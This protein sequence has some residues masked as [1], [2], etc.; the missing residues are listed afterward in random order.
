MKKFSKLNEYN[1]Q[2]E[3][4]ENIENLNKLISDLSIESEDETLN[5]M[6]EDLISIATCL[7]DLMES[8]SK[9]LNSLSK[10]FN[11]QAKICIDLLEGS[12][13]DYF[14]L[15]EKIKQVKLSL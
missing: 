13:E 3:V 14:E 15:I 12:D 9:F 11:L 2:D 6:C 5:E 4:D 1:T 7:K 8:E 10:V